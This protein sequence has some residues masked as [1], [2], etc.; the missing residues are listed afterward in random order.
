MHQ[1]WRHLKTLKI[2]PCICPIRREVTPL[3]SNSS[4]IFYTLHLLTC[5]SAIIPVIKMLLHVQV[6]TIIFIYKS[7]H[8]DF[9]VVATVRILLIVSIGNSLNRNRDILVAYSR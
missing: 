5:L 2:L 7:I 1:R 6:N 9:L 4:A 3:S 8:V